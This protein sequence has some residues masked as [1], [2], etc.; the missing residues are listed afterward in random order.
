M[1]AMK[2]YK[3]SELHNA[4]IY[5]YMISMQMCDEHFGNVTRSNWRF[6]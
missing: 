4:H 3:Q 5:S 1:K 2:E 6:L